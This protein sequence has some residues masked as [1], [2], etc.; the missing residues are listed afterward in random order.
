MHEENLLPS[1]A[2]S[3]VHTQTP[4]TLQPESLQRCSLDLRLLSPEQPGRFTAL[5]GKLEKRER[6]GRW[7]GGGVSVDP[8]LNGG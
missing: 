1:G 8:G 6:A 4:Q 7:R 2:A 3:E 5:S